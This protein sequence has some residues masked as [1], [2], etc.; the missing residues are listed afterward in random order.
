[1]VPQN[2]SLIAFTEN[3]Y[4]RFQPRIK[5]TNKPKFC[6]ISSGDHYFNFIGPKLILPAFNYLK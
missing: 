2:F 5:T 4:S 6:H 1:M 3:Y